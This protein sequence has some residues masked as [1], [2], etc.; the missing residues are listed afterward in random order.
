MKE[1]MT[2]LD[3]DK[4]GYAPIW[5]YE[6]WRIAM[7]LDTEDMHKENIKIMSKHMETDEVFVLLEGNANI[8]IGDGIDEFGKITKYEMVPGK[9]FNVRAGTWHATETLAGAKIYIVENRNTGD[10]NTIKLPVTP[11]MLP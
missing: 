9:A 6:T 3:S 2:I 7:I 1:C 8:Y 10:A 5:D 4:K 11:D